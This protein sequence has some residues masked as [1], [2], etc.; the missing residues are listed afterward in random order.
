MS[1]FL[2]D[3][4]PYFRQVAGQLALGSL[5]GIAMNTAV[6]LPPILLGRAIDAALR[7][8]RGQADAA[9]VGWAA[10]AFVGGTLLT[11]G[12]RV[13]KRW[14]L[15]TADARIRA[16]LRADAL[17][18]VLDWP[19][20]RLQATSVG[21]LMA[22]IIADV[23]VVSDGIHE[24][25][26]ET[27]D[28]VLFSLSLIVAMLFFDA[29]LT[30]LALLPVPLAMLIARFT[31][32]WVSS[33]TRA[34][35]EANADLTAALHEFLGGLRVLRLFGRASAAVERVAGLSHR[36][37]GANLATA[38]LKGGLQPLY[39]VLMTSGVL[40][41]IWQGGE[42]VIAGALTVGA[43]VAYLELYLRFVNR[44]FR[45]P[46]LVNEVQSAGAAFARLRPLLA[47]PPSRQGEPPLASFR[48]GR[49]T[50]YGTPAAL[51]AAPEVAG[52]AAVSLHQVTFCYPGATA[53][54]LTDVSLDI[55]AGALV[56][57]TGPVGS[58]KTSLARTLLG[59]YP[60]AVGE[61]FFEGRPLPTVPPAERAAR[62]GYLPQDGH[63][64]AGTIRD[65]IR[66]FAPADPDDSERAVGEAIQRA[67]LAED[68]ADFPA[69]PA[70]EIG[71]FGGRLSGGQRQRIALARA[72]AASPGGGPGLLVLDDPFSAVDLRT[73]AEIV[74]A[75]REAFGPAAPPDRRA[76]VVI[77]SH[78]LAVFPR[79][80][81]VV[82]LEGGRIAERGTHEALLRVGG[83]YARIYRA[84]QAVEQAAPAADLV[85]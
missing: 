56:A 71:E 22:R 37:A 27:W 6:V 69:G 18:G 10:L 77:C 45:V 58:G 26:V 67:A 55:P 15:N 46:Q 57:V 3:M 80:D 20:E 42:R 23:E 72:L 19:M 30:A 35:R 84:Q 5:A 47:P 53:P 13:L 74:T 54:A 16:D 40:L 48:P 21:D 31:G 64:F 39:T 73:E 59:L 28:T 51:P 85:V 60:L 43:F 82:V 52:P 32:R 68:L 50:G 79:A 75:L 1:H 62:I 49:V 25:I 17:R 2:W 70:T 36:L 66:L 8:E 78:R 12:P 63:L 29:G 83:L 14:W 7:F 34:A 33:R 38:R 61:V 81:L 11:E 41:L 76:T 24:V 44:G 65:N 4:R 9:T